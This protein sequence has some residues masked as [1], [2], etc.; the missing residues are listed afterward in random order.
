MKRKSAG[1]ESEGSP[2]GKSRE[3][4]RLKRVDKVFRHIE[5]TARN[6]SRLPLCRGYRLSYQN[7]VSDKFPQLTLRVIDRQNPDAVCPYIIFKIGE[8]DS[9]EI[10]GVFTKDRKEEFFLGDDDVFV[11][12]NPIIDELVDDFVAD[13]R[14]VAEE[15]QA[16]RDSR[17]SDEIGEEVV[18]IEVDSRLHLTQAEARDVKKMLGG[19]M[20]SG[21]DEA[22]PIVVDEGFELDGEEAPKAD[23][24]WRDDERDPDQTGESS[25]TWILAN[26][27]ATVIADRYVLRK[28][29]GTGGM[30]AVFIA[31]D[32]EK[33]RAVAIKMLHPTLA[34][35]QVVLRRF[36][37]EVQLIKA[38]EHENVIS[39]FDSGSFEKVI[40]YTMEYVRGMPLNKLVQ[41]RKLKTDALVSFSYQLACGLQ[42]IHAANIIHRDLKGENVIVTKD[43]K[44][45]IIDFGIA[46]TEDS[47]LTSMGEVIGSP[48]YLAPELWRGEVP[49][50]ASDIYALG[51]IFYRMS[52]GCLPFSGD[53]PVVV[54]NKHLHEKAVFKKNVVTA[55]P[56]WFLKLT[57]N[58]LRKDPKKRPTLDQLLQLLKSKLD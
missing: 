45:K 13:A 1:Q 54:M 31:D 48:A 11:G 7:S 15:R 38:V 19:I 46:R 4:A 24:Q 42:A 12:I 35:D 34:D 26:R 57:E 28:L 21:E 33:D 56:S 16:L 3:T 8:P 39:T 5:R 43:K 30:G 53:N 18:A 40:Y 51:V 44:I 2:S 50:P 9:P 14:K 22:D 23:G 20:G 49:T 47:N 25:T 6:A 52:Y 41:G 58:I 29:L 32:K 36:F 37:R 27:K 10:L 17:F 55:A